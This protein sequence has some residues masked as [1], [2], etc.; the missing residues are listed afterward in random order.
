MTPPPVCNDPKDR[1]AYANQT[2][3][4]VKKNNQGFSLIEFIVMIA[5]GSFLVS[6]LVL[7]TR[8][9]AVNGT[10]MRDFLVALDLARVKMA[11]M[12]NTAYASLTVGTTTLA[13]DASFPG[14]DI[15]RVI[16]LVNTGAPNPVTIRQIDIKIDYAGGTFSNP[17]IK[18]SAY[19]QSNTTFGDGI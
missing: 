5:V 17:L 9:Q 15:Q 16:T 1:F 10:Q 19:R 6:G 13:D 18:L 4:G 14:F 8:Q 2:G 3:G 7:F 11:E 12:N